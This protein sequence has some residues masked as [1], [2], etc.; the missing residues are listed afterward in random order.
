M[1]VNNLTQIDKS[2]LLDLDGRVHVNLYAGGVHD[3]QVAHEVLAVLADNHELRLPQLLVVG[4]LVVVGLTF[5]DLED[6]LSTIDGNLELFELL[7]VHRLEFHMELVGGGLIRLRIKCSAAEVKA[8]LELRGAQLTKLDALEI[9]RVSE[10][11]KSRVL[12]N[13]ET[14][15][16]RLNL[17]TADIEASLVGLD[18]VL[19]GV[20][21]FTETDSYDILDK[22]AD[23]FGVLR[24]TE[25]VVG[26]N[27][28]LLVGKQVLL[29][30]FRDLVE[31]A[32]LTDGTKKVVG[33]DGSLALEESEPEDLG[34]LAGESLHDLVGEVVVHDVLEVDLVEIVG[35][36]VQHGEALMLYAL[37]AELLDV[38][39]QE[40]K[41]G[42]VGLHGVGEVVLVDGLF[43]VADKGANSLDAGARLQVLSLDGEVKVVGDI[44]KALSADLL[45]DT[46]KDLFETLE[47]PVLVDASVDDAGVEDLLGFHGEKVAQVL[48]KVDLFVGVDVVSQKLGE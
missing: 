22:C 5:T 14:G 47:V 44:V 6:T 7:S 43:G 29:V 45:E 25:D 35:P 4:D 33:G 16:Q 18:L 37:V 21:S 17:V 39:L 32:E 36:G 12:I 10:A 15:G 38:L 1:V 13:L 8:G 41:V 23:L 30:V 48:D 28:G 40:L 26:V 34:V 31:L 2:I 19:E 27:S 24:Q 3:T 20:V 11:S 46:H 9:S 42:L